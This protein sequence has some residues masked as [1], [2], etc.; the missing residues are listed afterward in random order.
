MTGD[1]SDLLTRLKALLPGGWFRDATPVLDGF[2][3]GIAWA[4]SQ[5]HAL[6][7]YARLQTRILTATDGFLDLISFD[8]FGATLPRRA[9]E[10]DAAF[11]ARILAEL[12]LEKGTRKGL[13]RVLE[14][15][16]GRTPWV[17]EPGRPADTGGYN[18]TAMGYGVAGGYGSLACPFQAFVVA[19]RPTGQGIPNVG[20]YGSTVGAYGTPSQLE[21][22]NPSLIRGAVTDADI[23]AAIDSV[24]PAGTIL[25][26]RI[27][28]TAPASPA[29]ALLLGE[30]GNPLLAEDGTNILPE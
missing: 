1:Q 5:A 14:I 12:L 22:A 18:S 27:G 30:D 4:L 24:K 7:A 6:A 3:N 23:Y 15:L 26:T 2:L 21:Y 25:W 29:D 19:Y 9:L 13:I 16:T 20:G 28:D 11:R 8:F 10:S 17:F